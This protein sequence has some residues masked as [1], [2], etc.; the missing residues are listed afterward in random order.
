MAQ[1]AQT[2]KKRKKKKRKKQS[3]R[4]GVLIAVLVAALIL[5]VF[6]L[7]RFLR[8]HSAETTSEPEVS[9][10]VAPTLPPS[11]LSAQCF[12]ESDGYKTY[13]SDTVTA[14]LGVDISRHQEWVDWEALAASPGYSRLCGAGGAGAICRCGAAPCEVCCSCCCP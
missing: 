14:K 4:S 12:G 8:S 2:K 13:V 7:F 9:V 10:S 11:G 3:S 5:V 1:T 6:V